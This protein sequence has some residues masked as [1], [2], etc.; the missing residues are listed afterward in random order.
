M[1]S[2][3]H[4]LHE[5]GLLVIPAQ[6]TNGIH[7]PIH[8]PE[9]H[10]V[11]PLVQILKGCLHGIRVGVVAFVVIGEE[12]LQDGIGIAAVIGRVLCH[13]A[14]QYLH[15]LIHPLHHPSSLPASSCRPGG[16]CSGTADTRP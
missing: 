16:S 3:L 7:D 12:H 13:M 2:N 14:F 6:G 9:G 1:N 10:T 11:H 5:S 8:L 15:I 4:T